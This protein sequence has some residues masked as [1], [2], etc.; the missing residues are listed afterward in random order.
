MNGMIYHVMKL[1]DDWDV[2]DESG[3]VA[4]EPLLRFVRDVYD[5]TLHRGLH[6][7]EES[8]CE[9]VNQMAGDSEVSFYWFKR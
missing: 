4:T 6:P 7:D 3:H 5:V 2:F 9:W 1:E 8:R